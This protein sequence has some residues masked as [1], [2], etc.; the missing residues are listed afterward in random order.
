MSEITLPDDEYDPLIA[1][2]KQYFLSELDRE[3]GQFEA[4]FVIDFFVAELGPR[5]YN[6]ALVDA[7]AVVE[8]RAE[9]ISEAINEIEKDIP[10]S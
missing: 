5:I 7:R 1:K 8:T 10:R 9:L 2:V 3:L 6:S 4:R